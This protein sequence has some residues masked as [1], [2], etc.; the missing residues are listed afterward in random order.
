MGNREEFERAFAGATVHDI[1]NWLCVV[2]LLP[3]EVA[4][5][6]LYTLS[7]AVLSSFQFEQSDGVKVELLS[8]ITKPFTRK[9]VQVITKIRDYC[10]N[11][12]LKKHS[13]VTHSSS[14]T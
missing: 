2:V 6:Y 14:F 3:L 4:T 10:R 12:N 8:K 9:I 5:G 13:Y 1:F 7:K 11:V